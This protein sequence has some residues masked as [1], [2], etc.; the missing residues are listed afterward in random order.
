MM[1]TRHQRA[2][3][4]TLTELVVVMVIIGILAAVA[5]PRLMGRGA[6]DARGFEDQV[7]AALQYARQQAVAQRRVVC[8]ALASGSVAI[9]RAPAPPPDGLCD[10]TP[11]L[12]P[13]TGAA[14]AVNAPSGIILSGISVALPTT[15]S[16]D[17]LGRPRFAATLRVQ[18]DDSHCLSV[19]AETG[20][21]RDI[22][23]P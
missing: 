1:K 20:Y 21:V 12:N 22:T 10:A 8:V 14:Y 19:E 7:I 6:F 18:G 9:T 23:C 16:F 3:G 4:F 11:L 13:A 5:G 15:L 2:S 17:Q